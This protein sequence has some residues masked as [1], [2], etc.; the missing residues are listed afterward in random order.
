LPQYRY[1]TPRK[2]GRWHPDIIAA[3]RAAAKA[4]EAHQDEY[5]KIWLSPMTT[6]EIRALPGEPAI[7]TAKRPS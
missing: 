1:V 4:G 5:G 2:K 7:R 3:K 6:I